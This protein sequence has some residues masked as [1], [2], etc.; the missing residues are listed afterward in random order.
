MRTTR[1]AA[2]LALAAWPLAVAVDSA[3]GIALLTGVTAG[4]VALESRVRHA[5]VEA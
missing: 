4:A 5:T 2:V 1:A 3:A